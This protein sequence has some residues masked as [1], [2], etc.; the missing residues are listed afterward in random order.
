MT[1]IFLDVECYPNYFLVM[2]KKLDGKVKYF[3]LDED[4]SFDIDTLEHYLHTYETIGFNTRNYDM[5]MIL[6]ALRGAGNKALKILSDRI[7]S[8]EESTYDILCSENLW[9]PRYYNHIDLFKVLPGTGASLKMCGARLQSEKLQDLPYPPDQNLNQKQ[10]QE[11]LTYCVNDVDLT[12]DLY[13]ALSKELE[14]REDIT[15]EYK[16]DMRSKSD[17][18]IAESLLRKQLSTISDPLSD[19]KFKYNKPSYISF[20][21]PVLQKLLSDTESIEFIGN[22][23][24]D[25]K[26][27]NSIPNEIIIKDKPYSFGIGGLH[28]A[29]KNRAIVTSNDEMLIDLDVVSYYP[30]I[31]LNNEYSPRQLDKQEFLELY[32]K[33][34][35]E[36]IEAK[37]NGDIFKSQVFKIILNGSFGKFGDRYSKLLYD[38]E[39]LVHTT[40]TGQLSLLMLIEILE[41][42]G[43]SVV[44]ANT[45]G[46]AVYFK[47]KD[48]KTLQQLI[49]NWQEKTALKLEETR[50]KALYNESVNSYIAIKEDGSLKCKGHFVTGSLSNN[51]HVKVCNQA[52]IDY[53][54]KDIPVEETIENAEKT[55]E[56]FTLFIKVA[57]GGIWKGQYLGKVVR[58]Y[59]VTNGE[60]IYRQSEEVELKKDGTPKKDVKVS[61]SDGACPLMDLSVPMQNLDTSRYIAEC[62]KMLENI[63]VNVEQNRRAA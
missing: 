31:I 34:F 60:P 16:M 36:R 59:W 15:K 57:S 6:Y 7:I 38:P 33:I 32:R 1:K 35:N 18:Q 13:K 55:P 12:I 2:L 44:S 48:Y 22:R 46:I 11:V 17:A 21:T 29:E 63:G 52:V 5:P 47:T 61:N 53:L 25:I 41:L 9:C 20:E 45:D 8:K 30:S 14:I 26:K 40:L 62:Y 43:F 28:S 24:E 54:T 10:K 19:Y 27:D 50:Y 51:A 4:K 37:Q 42:N 39:M 56:N 23:D 58:W 3:E 49:N